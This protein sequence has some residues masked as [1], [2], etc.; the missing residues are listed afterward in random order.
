M[1]A[2][3]CQL[4]VVSLCALAAPLRSQVTAPPTDSAA[5][6]SAIAELDSA[7][8][9][10]DGARWT[11]M[12]LPDAEFVNVSG[13]IFT[14]SNDI[15][16]R[17]EK[18]WHEHFRGSHSTGAIRRLVFLNPD[19]A[20]ADVNFAVKGYA[21]LPRVGARETAPGVILSRMRHV[22]VRKDGHWRITATQNT[23]VA[24]R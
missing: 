16:A 9:A 17:H 21:Y 7:W 19:V 24:P 23:L 12:F 8:A 11:A 22:F 10:A 6:K 4:L 15:R 20:I 2:S 5:I 14:G 18:I 13:L 1:K 3:C